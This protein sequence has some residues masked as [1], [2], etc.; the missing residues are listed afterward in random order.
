[1]EKPEPLDLRDLKLKD[2]QDKA[3]L[4]QDAEAF[5]EK[6][7]KEFEGKISSLEE[8]PTKVLDSF[9]ADFS[10]KETQQD[11]VTGMILNLTKNYFEPAIG[12]KIAP[13]NPVVAKQAAILF[14]R[15]FVEQGLSVLR[16]PKKIKKID[17][18]PVKTEEGGFMKCEIKGEKG[19][20]L[21][22]YLVP[23]TPEFF[24]EIRAQ[25]ETIKQPVVLY[26]LNQ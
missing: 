2:F 19:K 15:S 6:S 9:S 12:A 11:H 10:G 8:D 20:V 17:F 1:M 16:E 21:G 25:K 23:F 22:T 24:T 5:G 7:M 14:G 26:F 4:D 13:N 3:K 18:T